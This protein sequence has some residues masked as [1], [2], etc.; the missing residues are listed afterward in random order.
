MGGIGPMAG[1]CVRKSLW[2]S[3]VGNFVDLESSTKFPT[4]FPTK[5]RKGG[6]STR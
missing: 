4:K 6:G 3:F 5:G 2:P 1:D